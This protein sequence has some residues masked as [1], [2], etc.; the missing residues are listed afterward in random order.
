VSNGDEGLPQTLYVQMCV[1]RHPRRKG[2][3]EKRYRQG[4]HENQQHITPRR[5]MYVYMY[6]YIYIEKEKE[7]TM[8][9]LAHR[10]AAAM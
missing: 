1:Y 4:D 9:I 5:Y 3:G 2:E 7:E 6:M 10:L 8:S